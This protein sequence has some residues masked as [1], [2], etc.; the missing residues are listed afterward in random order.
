MKKRTDNDH[1]LHAMWLDEAAK[2]LSHV[3]AGQT[4]GARESLIALQARRQ[5]QSIERRDVNKNSNARRR[6]ISIKA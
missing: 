2:G 6:L 1:K 5:Q 3:A 4:N